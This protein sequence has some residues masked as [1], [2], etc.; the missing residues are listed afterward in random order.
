MCIGFSEIDL[1]RSDLG[2][3][4]VD[5]IV[6]CIFF[7]MLGKWDQLNITGFGWVHF[8]LKK[9]TNR[10][11]RDPYRESDDADR[12]KLKNKKSISFLNFLRE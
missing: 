4:S 11:V 3:S 7:E 9:P 5:V 1:I 6:M 2:L 8:C 10:P 12:T